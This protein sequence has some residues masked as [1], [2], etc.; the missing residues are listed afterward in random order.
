MFVGQFENSL[1][2]KSAN[3]SKSLNN[4]GTKIIQL[5]LGGLAYELAKYGTN[6][7]ARFV[8]ATDW[9]FLEN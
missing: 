5:V 3:I 6:L 9:N 8:F 7:F 1:F 2:V 4:S